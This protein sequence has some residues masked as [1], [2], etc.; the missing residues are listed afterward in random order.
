MYGFIL[1]QIDAFFANDNYYIFSINKKKA[2]KNIRFHELFVDL[3]CMETDKNTVQLDKYNSVLKILI[4]TY[5]EN[6]VIQQSTVKI[7]Q[8]LSK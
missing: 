6:P 4:C 5:I 3:N 7:V 2:R 1:K 8:E